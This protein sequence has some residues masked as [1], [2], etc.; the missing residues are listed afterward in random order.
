MGMWGDAVLMLGG[1]PLYH[2]FR[3]ACLY[4]LCGVPMQVPVWLCVLMAVTWYLS[5]ILSRLYLGV[6]SVLVRKC[7]LN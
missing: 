4:D 6:H 1:R 5:V 7:L 2:S 3:V